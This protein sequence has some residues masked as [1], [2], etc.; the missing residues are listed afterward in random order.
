MCFYSKRI[1]LG[2]TRFLSGTVKW[3]PFPVSAA[4]GQDTS[5]NYYREQ[6]NINPITTQYKSN[7]GLIIILLLGQLFF[8]IIK[9]RNIGSMVF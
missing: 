3:D 7:I 9:E 2:G 6:H 1:H 8:P 5:Q 4:L